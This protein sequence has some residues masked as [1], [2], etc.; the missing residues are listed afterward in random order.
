M[1]N[2]DKVTGKEKDNTSP[3]AARPS[4]RLVLVI[5][6]VRGWST[7][8]IDTRHCRQDGTTG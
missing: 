3:V 5:T 7:P 1:D 6:I 4:V 2:T 8:T